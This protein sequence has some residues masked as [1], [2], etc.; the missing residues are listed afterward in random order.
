MKKQLINEVA[1]MKRLAGLITESQYEATVAVNED[2][3][4]ED[5]GQ[6]DDRNYDTKDHIY[7]TFKEWLQGLI[8][9]HGNEKKGSLGVADQIKKLTKDNM[10]AT[11]EDFIAQMMRWG[12]GTPKYINFYSEDGK[13][14]GKGTYPYG[15][16]DMTKGERGVGVV[17]PPTDET[18]S[19][20]IYP[21]DEVGKSLGFT[22]RTND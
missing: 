9:R 6:G 13:I 1:R 5:L 7:G 8:E 19:S 3:D 2:G 18:P 16:W 10:D 4:Y 14:I 11:P 21:D 12:S 20:L 15:E 17:H 22:P